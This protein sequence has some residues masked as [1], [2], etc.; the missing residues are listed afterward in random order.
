MKDFFRRFYTP[1]NASLAIAGDFDPAAARRQALRFS[2]PRF[3]AEFFAFLD[4]VLHPK[5]P[6]ARQAA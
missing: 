3:A 5:A 6:A 1:N 2:R 4:G